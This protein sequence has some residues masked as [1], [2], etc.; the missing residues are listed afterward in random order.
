MR[1][2]ITT[3]LVIATL[4]F[5]SNA[6]ANTPDKP[7]G[8][9]TASS[10][11]TMPASIIND[12]SVPYEVLTYAQLQYEGSAVTKVEKVVR[13]GKEIY[14][15]RVD[16]DDLSDDYNSIFLVY[17][18]KWLL[19]GE[20]RGTAPV[21]KKQD[22]APTA[23]PTSQPAPTPAAQQSEGGRGGSAPTAEANPSQPT[24]PQEPTGT[25]ENTTTD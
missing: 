4:G 9:I 20:E 21:I 6:L 10:A 25:P 16:K 22:P 2:L 3:G 11:A 13:D 19:L 14:R 1:K 15:L 5:S 8:A 24:G 7:T 17:D 18:S 12:I 23:A